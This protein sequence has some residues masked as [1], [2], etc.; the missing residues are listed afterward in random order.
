[1]LTHYIEHINWIL[2]T[3]HVPSFRRQYADFWDCD[4]TRFDLI[5][6]SLLFAVISVSALYIPSDVIEAGGMPRKAVRDLAHVWHR[7]SQQALEA[8]QYEANPTLRQ[9]QTY[10]VMQ[11][12]WYATNDVET[13]NS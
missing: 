11:L 13:L 2:H 6:V 3:V 4:V 8:G 1:L 7:A 12:Y 9:L 5:W 10:S